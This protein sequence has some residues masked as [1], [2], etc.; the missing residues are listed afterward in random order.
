MAG[1]KTKKR[2]KRREAV[3]DEPSPAPGKPPKSKVESRDGLWVVT[4]GRMKQYGDCLIEQPGQVIRKQ[5]LK[6]DDVLLKHNYVRPLRDEEE[7]EQCKT[8][9][10]VFTGSV[11]TGAY[12]AHLGRAR[13]DLTQA[14]LDAGIER[15]APKKS[16]EGSE[17][18]PDAD[19]AGE[20]DL[21]PE[22]SPPPTKLESE[23]PRGVQTTL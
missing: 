15:R 16:R 6:N 17:A 2:S 8:C 10:L 9:G 4:S 23:F 21:E 20:W 7:M 3:V 13:H 5:H 11:T 19:N 12:M 18:N 1:T 14:D 22:G